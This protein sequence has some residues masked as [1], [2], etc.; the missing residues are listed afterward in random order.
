MEAK[1]LMHC[2]FGFFGS[3]QSDPYIVVSI[4]ARKF[5]TRVIKKTVN[6]VYGEVW[7]AVVEIVK[8][9]SLVMSVWDQ[10]HSKDDD[11]MGSARIPLASLAER[12]EADLWVALEEASSG[13]VRIRTEWFEVSSERE[14]YEV[15]Q[16][17]THGRQLATA[18]LLLYIDRWVDCRC[19][20]M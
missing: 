1:N 5:K 15:R 20:S 13:Q 11:F 17:E 2:D 14:D 6:P 16:E 12:G 3:G 18:L 9:Q 10:D 4:G 19:Y 7:E 8:G